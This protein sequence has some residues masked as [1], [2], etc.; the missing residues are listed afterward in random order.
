MIRK[1]SYSISFPDATRQGLQPHRGPFTEETPELDEGPNIIPE[2]SV[3]EQSDHGSSSED[4]SRDWEATP[5]LSLP[6]HPVSSTM[7]KQS[8]RNTLDDRSDKSSTNKSGVVRPWPPKVIDPWHRPEDISL[9]E[10]TISAFTEMGLEESSITVPKQWAYTSRKPVISSRLADALCAT[11][12]VQGILDQLNTILRTSYTT[13]MPTLSSLLEECIANQYDFG[14]AYSR[15]RR[16]WYTDDWS[17]I[18]ARIYGWE[19]EDWEMRRKALVG[20]RVI[21][22]RL[23]PRRVWDLYSNRVVPSWFTSM[24]ES[25]RPLL[26]AWV[27]EKDREAVW[28]PINGYEWAVPIPY[29]INLN[30]VRIEMLNLEEE[31]AWLDVLCLRQVGGPGEAIRSEEWKLDVPT[32]G[33]VYVDNFVVIYLSGLG[34][35]LSLK[36][37]DLDSDRSWFRC[38]WTLQEVGEDRVFAGDSPDG[39]QHAKPV[40]DKRNYETKLLT[41]F[42]RQLKSIDN[43]LMYE[44]LEGMQDR[45]STNPVDKIAGLAF[46]M[47]TDWIPA[48]YESQSIEEA[49]A[50]LVNAMDVEGR[51]K[52]FL[53]SPEPGNAGAKWRP[54]W[55]QVMTKPQ[56]DSFYTEIQVVWDEEM[57]EDR[58]NVDSIEKGLVQGLAAVEE[59]DRCGE[60]II[61]D[62]I[63]KEHIF[64]IMAAHECPIPEDMYT[65][66]PGY[67]YSPTD[68]HF[69][70]VIGQRQGK[71]FEKVSLVRILDK[72]QWN[73]LVKD[74]HIIKKHQYILV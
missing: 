46:L 35:P 1:R 25:I 54:S 38:A 26:H 48:Y 63:G 71:R 64:K 19:E 33:S 7:E 59:G 43:L 3:V 22:P 39:P 73:H 29:D 12:G 2:R 61:K 20:N 21:D 24:D 55:D 34:R 65:L 42:H 18:Q 30:L 13:D 27:T 41:R 57:N 14:M 50:A 23:P 60:L 40:D 70:C 51:G 37:G 74:L 4:V 66:I 44:A 31:Y 58:C 72:E 69:Y 52:L 68:S 67:N 53:S 11:L 36:E 15:L 28:T 16:V 56:F 47:D 8:S 10:V 5:E 17:T 9:P 32:I 49:W 45:L 62:R 6:S